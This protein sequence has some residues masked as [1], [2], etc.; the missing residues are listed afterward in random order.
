MGQRAML[1][2]SGIAPHVTL[3][4]AFTVIALMLDKNGNS[5]WRQPVVLA[6]MVLGIG[7]WIV[8]LALARKAR[9]GVPVQLGST[10]VIVGILCFLVSR[11]N[12]ETA[13]G[14]SL[15]GVALLFVGTVMLFMGI[16]QHQGQPQR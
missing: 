14:W 5:A 4:L 16:R 13:V 11:L 8:L 9:M 6:A 1:Q 2:W 15:G 12:D 10:A 7:A 3:V